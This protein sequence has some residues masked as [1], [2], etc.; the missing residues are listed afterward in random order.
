[1]RRVRERLATGSSIRSRLGAANRYVPFR[2]G[3]PDA[4]VDVVRG[5][6]NNSEVVV[7]VS[8]STAPGWISLARSSLL[9]GC[10]RARRSAQ[11]RR[12]C[13]RVSWGGSAR[14]ADTAESEK[15][16]AVDSR[17]PHAPRHHSSSSALARASA[18]SVQPRSTG[19]RRSRRS[20]STRRWPRPRAR[21][22]LHSR[23]SAVRACEAG[24][25]PTVRLGRRPSATKKTKNGKRPAGAGL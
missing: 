6:S 16:A 14:R 22:L 18:T 17:H 11:R 9:T 24:E 23:T 20:R 21:T 12:V 15:S 3:R 1:M 25:I 5:G 4:S 2:R 8:G 7:V 19:H 13:G 10:H